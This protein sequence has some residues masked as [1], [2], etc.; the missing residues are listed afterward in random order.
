MTKPSSPGQAGTSESPATCG[1]SSPS[2]LA[3]EGRED[4]AGCSASAAG[5]HSGLVVGSRSPSLIAPRMVT[6]SMMDAGVKVLHQSGVVEY[7]GSGDCLVVKEIFEA[8]LAAA[9]AGQ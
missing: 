3:S 8:M 9:R 2:S 1:A 5:R 7:P 4:A 6:E